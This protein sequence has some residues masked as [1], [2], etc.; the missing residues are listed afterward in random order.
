VLGLWW[1][2]NAYTV[3]RSE[4]GQL[5]L[6]IGSFVVANLLIILAGAFGYEQLENVLQLVWLA[7]CAY[8]WFAPGLFRRLLQQEIRQ[9]RLDPDY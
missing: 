2:A 7:F 6:L 1:R 4:R 9:V 3:L 5:A 8:T